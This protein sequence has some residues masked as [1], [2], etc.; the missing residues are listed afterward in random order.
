[1]GA[2]YSGG[3]VARAALT[4]T[5]SLAAHSAVF[6]GRTR[7]VYRALAS[8]C[9]QVSVTSGVDSLGYLTCVARVRNVCS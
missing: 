6:L 1:M 4:A 3:L 2:G 5:T 9:Q 7:R 8:H